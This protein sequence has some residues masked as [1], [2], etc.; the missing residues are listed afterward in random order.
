MQRGRFER[1]PE[2]SYD[3]VFWEI[4]RIVSVRFETV[5]FVFGCFDIDS[6]HRNKPK[7]KYFWF[8][9]TKQTRNRSCFGLFRFEPKLF[10]FHFEDTLVQSVKK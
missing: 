6:K 8:H 10:F 4:F 7:K 9:E 3:R 5:L 1:V 2:I